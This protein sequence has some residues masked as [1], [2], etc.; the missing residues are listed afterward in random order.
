MELIKDTKNNPYKTINEQMMESMS[1]INS[2][3]PKRKKRIK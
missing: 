3:N 1:L 2:I